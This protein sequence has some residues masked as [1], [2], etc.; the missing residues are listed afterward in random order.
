M[1]RVLLFLTMIL[2]VTGVMV[3]S[4]PAAHLELEGRSV[5]VG[6]IPTDTIVERVMRIRNTGDAPLVIK[7]IFAECGCTTPSSPKDPILPG[8]WGEIKVR[9]N[10]KGRPPGEFR[11]VLRIRSNADNSRELFYIRGTVRRQYRK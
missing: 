9:F 8:E 5:D 10:S 6:V 7:R 3:A 1:K 2:M 4:E 11:K